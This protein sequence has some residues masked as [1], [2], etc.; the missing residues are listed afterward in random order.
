[1]KHLFKWGAIHKIGNGEKTQFWDDVW[2]TSSPIF[3]LSFL[4]DLYAI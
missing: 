3:S 2:L 1:V 4:S